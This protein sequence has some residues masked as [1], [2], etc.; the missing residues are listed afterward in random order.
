MLPYQER[1][2]SEYS[3]LTEKLIKLDK[4]LFGKGF[5]LLTPKEQHRLIKQ[6]AY[7]RAY[8][9]VLGERIGSF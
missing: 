8:A 9:D 1:V 6:S 2:V 4:F 7:M 5:D 3:D